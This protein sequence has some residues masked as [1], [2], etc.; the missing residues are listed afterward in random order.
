MGPF[1]IAGIGSI[2]GGI[3][4]LFGGDDDYQQR[5]QADN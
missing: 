3:G 2:L 1:S 4:D 5:L